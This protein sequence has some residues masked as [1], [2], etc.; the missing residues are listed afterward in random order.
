MRGKALGKA[1]FEPPE[2]TVTT[3]KEDLADPLWGTVKH[4]VV[5]RGANKNTVRK[6]KNVLKFL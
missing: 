6:G 1:A 5:G 3:Q 2:L 4:P